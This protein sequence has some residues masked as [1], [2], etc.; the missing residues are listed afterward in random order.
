MHVQMAQRVGGELPG[1]IDLQDDAVLVELGV[2]RGDLA[3]AEG[4]VQ[5][6]VNGL[7]GHAQARGGVAVDLQ[8]GLGRRRLAV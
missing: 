4:V 5:R 6:V 3:L 8:G 7:Y 1:R 2:Q